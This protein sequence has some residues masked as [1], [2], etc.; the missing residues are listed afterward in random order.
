MLRLTRDNKA[1]S[2]VP[3]TP[4]TIASWNAPIIDRPV[5]SINAI[6]AMTNRPGAAWQSLESSHATA[7][8]IKSIINK[9]A[10]PPNQIALIA[11]GKMT[12]ADKALNVNSLGSSRGNSCAIASLA[13]VELAD[14]ASQIILRKIRPKRIEKHELR[15]SK[16][17]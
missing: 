9:K 1:I 12:A 6:I 15:I 17:P 3:K 16:L 7:A 10:H 14:S 4:H 11:N 13:A 5:V 2:S 8:E